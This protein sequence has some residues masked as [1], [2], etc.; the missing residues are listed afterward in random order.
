ME[1][2]AILNKRAILIQNNNN[3]LGV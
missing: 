2:I 3:R 1:F